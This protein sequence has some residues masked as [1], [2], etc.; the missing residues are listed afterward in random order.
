MSKQH[1]LGKSIYEKF[2]LLQPSFFETILFVL[3][4][5]MSIK[6][7]IKRYIYNDINISHRLI[8]N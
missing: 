2:I 5:V 1:Q 4:I 6:T 3:I 8:E 7:D